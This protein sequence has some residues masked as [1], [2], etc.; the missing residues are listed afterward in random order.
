MRRHDGM[1]EKKGVEN[2]VRC[3]RDQY[4]SIEPSR[5]YLFPPFVCAIECTGYKDSYIS[6]YIYMYE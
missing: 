3:E 2:G 5:Y 4:R 6:I 1:T